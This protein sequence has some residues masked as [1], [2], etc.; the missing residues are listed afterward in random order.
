MPYSSTA[1]ILIADV[2]SDCMIYF[3]LLKWAVY[4]YIITSIS[5]L[6]DRGAFTPWETLNNV[7]DYVCSLE[8]NAQVDSKLKLK[9]LPW[10]VLPS[11]Q[12]TGSW[13]NH[14]AKD[15]RRS[16]APS[17]VQSRVSSELRIGCSGLYLVRVWNT[18]PVEMVQP[19]RATC[20]SAQKA[21]PSI[22]PEFLLRSLYARRLS[23]SHQAPQWRAWLRLLD[24]WSVGRG[25][26]VR[27]PHAIPSP[28]WSSPSALAHSDPRLSSLP[29]VDAF[30]VTFCLP[31]MIA[32]WFRYCFSSRVK[33][34]D[35]VNWSRP[36][37]AKVITGI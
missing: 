4:F 24:D 18:S 17:P 29:L 33:P 25:A 36:A 8:A 14:S 19:H 28:G 11:V 27:A 6:G 20:S 2:S 31:K 5:S 10:L 37:T 23:L 3:S 13:K 16:V 22:Q 32:P 9:S 35:A 7:C 1:I 12:V 21:H 34:L 26:A 15:L 30:L